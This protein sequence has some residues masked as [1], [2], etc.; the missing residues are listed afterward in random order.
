V[1]GMPMKS[2]NFAA[3]VVAVGLLCA[4]IAIALLFGAVGT[5]VYGLTLIVTG[6]FF[7][8]FPAST[9]DRGGDVN[10]NA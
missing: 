4:T 10:G 2:A 8:R 1:I 9:I 3:A 5:L 6:L 7:I